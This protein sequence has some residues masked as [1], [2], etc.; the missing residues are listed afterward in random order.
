[1]ILNVI[2]NSFNHS[3]IDFMSSI[4]SNDDIISH[5]VTN[6]DG[7]TAINASSHITPISYSIV[8]NKEEPIDT[9]IPRGTICNTSAINIDKYITTFGYCIVYNKQEPIANFYSPRVASVN[10]KPTSLSS[11]IIPITSYC[12][13]YN[14]QE[15][16]LFINCNIPRMA[17]CNIDAVK[18]HTNTVPLASYSIVYNKQSP[19]RTFNPMMAITNS[20]KHSQYSKVA[21][22]MPMSIAAV[23]FNNKNDYQDYKY[24][25]IYTP[26]TDVQNKIENVIINNKYIQALRKNLVTYTTKGNSIKQ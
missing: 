12:V 18:V 11:Y 14:K 8:Y 2:S 3:S 20:N 21:Y 17:I 9:H 24:S 13:V 4:K 16:N 19:I 10:C 25:I 26:S 15:G 23:N 22:S 6:A 1:M 5:F 7:L